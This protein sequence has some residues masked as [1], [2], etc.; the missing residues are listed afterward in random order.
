MKILYRLFGFV[1]TFL[2]LGALSQ[3]QALNTVAALHGLTNEQAARHLPA[4]FDATVTYF[5]P[6]ERT[7][8]V[9]DGNTAIYVLAP[10][11]LQLIPGDRIHIT[12]TTQESFRP[13]VLGSSI[14]LLRHGPPLTSTPADF[15]HL[16]HATLDCRLVTVRARVMSADIVLSSGVRSTTL[17]LLMD[18]GDLESDIDSD[19]AAALPQLLDAEVEVTGA[20]SGRFDGKM[21]MTGVVLH[22]QSLADI[23][24]LQLPSVSPW[25][26]P[27]TPMDK[28]LAG[29]HLQNLNQR[30]HVRGVITYY[31]PGAALVLQDGSKSLWIATGTRSSLQIGDL[32]DA[33]G[34]PDV[35]DGFLNLTRGEIVDSHRSSPVA[36]VPVTAEE[37][38][39]SHHVFDL[40]SIQATVVAEVREDGQG[41]YV[42][43]S[44]R[45]LFSAILRDPEPIDQ[46]G[47]AA[48]PIAMKQIPLGSTV[49]VSG[50]VLMR[51]SNPFNAEVPFDLLM[52][53]LDD[54]VVVAHPSWVSVRNLFRLVA[55]LLAAVLAIGAWG[56]MQNRK[57]VQQ[58]AALARRIEAEAMRERRNAQIEQRRSQILEDIN[59][60]RPLVEILEEIAGL[61][62]FLFDGAPCWC[63][64]TEG[65]VLGQRPSNLDGL[66]LLRE[67]IPARTGPPLGQLFVAL[68]PH[69]PILSSEQAAMVVGSRLATLALETRRLYSDLVHRSEF[70]LLTGVHNRFSLDKHLESLIARAREQASI[71]GLIY[72]DLDA[73]KQVND[74]YGHHVG[75]LYLQEVSRRMKKQLRAGD[76]LARLG[77]DEF[78]ILVP[79][80]HGRTDVMDIAHRLCASFK[81]PFRVDE[82]SLQGSASVGIALYPEDGA[83]K[84]AL[85]RAA[86]TAMYASKH[87]K[88]QQEQEMPRR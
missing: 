66:R 15:D 11:N 38:N 78:A 47:I 83:N 76:L 74:L 57:V 71:F 59:G 52:R 72:V 55:L 39:R 63:Q 42:L 62:S 29:Y 56:W 6:Y 12:G 58:T 67:E 73:F 10:A 45:H 24:V 86:D 19:D 50:V 18:G 33:T 65:A 37:L 8:F 32:A 70:D 77:G 35:H 40:I 60:T 49:R 51:D 46:T 87:A 14:T 75:D 2:P 84:S 69:A 88:C 31:H 30:V 17:H 21:Q 85:L 53:S 22:S 26:L 20:V 68:P 3:S 41:I 4:E 80:A 43:S 5:R 13:F 27:I 61:V 16:I 79:T 54:I 82:H 9:Q 64:V 34:F 48:G 23:Q 25:T 1:F 7:L 81:E 44:G 36:P 28:I